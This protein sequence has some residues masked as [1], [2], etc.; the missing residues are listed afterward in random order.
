MKPK[1]GH[2]RLT[3]HRPSIVLSI[4]RYFEDDAEEVEES[5]TGQRQ[6]LTVN[7]QKTE[8]RFSRSLYLSERIQTMA[9]PSKGIFRFSIRT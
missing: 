6:V 9:G 4:P 3:R 7:A 5:L 2:Q 1:L 8:S